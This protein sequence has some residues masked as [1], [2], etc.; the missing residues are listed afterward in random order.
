MIDGARRLAVK[1]VMSGLAAVSLAATPALADKLMYETGDTNR[2]TVVDNDPPGAAAS[3]IRD[4]A[5]GS[6]VIQLS[7]VG[8][9]NAFRI[10]GTSTRNGG[11]NDTRRS[12]LSLQLRT[13]EN[14]LLYVVVQTR[15]GIRFLIYEPRDNDRGLI[16]TRHIYTGVGRSAV[17]DQ[18]IRLERDLAADLEAGE[19]GNRLLSVHGVIARG[20]IRLDDIALSSDP[21]AFAGADTTSTGT[22]TGTSSS[23]SD[24]TITST[25]ASM[26]STGTTGS[27]AI[28]ESGSTNG[29]RVIDDKPSGA[30]ASIV[31]DAALGS[32]VIQLEG[33]RLK[34]AYSLGGARAANGGWNDKE[35]AHLSLKLR[36]SEAY[37]LY[38]AVQ[39]RRGFRYLIY[40]PRNEDRGLIRSRF[41]YNGVGSAT[42][43]GKWIMIA[44]DLAA[45]LDAGEPGNTL[46]SV[47]GLVVRGNI[48]IDDVVLASDSTLAEASSPPSFSA[49]PGGTEGSGTSTGP[50]TSAG[51][52][53][54]NDADSGSGSDA[55]SDSVTRE[56]TARTP[57]ADAN[58]A[59]TVGAGALVILDGSA[60]TDSDGHVVEAFGVSRNAT[61][62]ARTAVGSK[63]HLSGL[64]PARTHWIGKRGRSLVAELRSLLPSLRPGDAV[65]VRNGSYGMEADVLRWPVKA[66]GTASA[67]IFLM[68]ETLGGVKFSGGLEWRLAGKHLHVSGF[69]FTGTTAPVLLQGDYTRFTSNAFEQAR[70]GLG[71]YASHVEIDNNV[72]S[73]TRGQSLWHAQPQIGCGRNCVYFKHNR[74]HHNTWKDIPRT[75]SNG[76]E[77]IML[78]YGY[79]PVPQGYDNATHTRIDHNLFSNVRGDAEVISIKSNANT[80]EHNCIIDSGDGA[81]VVRMGDD[82]R[83]RNNEILAASTTAIR[84]SG[85]SNRIEHNVFET[86]NTAA[87]GIALH[88]SEKVKSSDRYYRYHAA[89]DN[90][91]ARNRFIG[92]HFS[93]R[94]YPATGILV[95]ASSN[96][97]VQQNHFDAAIG[98]EPGIRADRHRS[99]AE[100]LRD[101]SISGNGA[102]SSLPAHVSACRP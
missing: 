48:R 46:L 13:A 65:V 34:N 27:T 79:A 84:I 87:A 52:N 75:K 89:K 40:E 54:G 58:S 74:I 14:F 70:I 4:A 30:R 16:G 100:F 93:T 96:N 41:L 36:T 67:P 26:G 2:W 80:V 98:I 68:A 37:T 66:S 5:L 39:T 97:V 8:R 1:L 50:D 9:S 76:L 18:W 71:I 92:Y 57:L 23:A 78:G 62:G 101:N 17:S 86:A 63:R 90:T 7:G 94:D 83:L 24:A 12:H 19:S 42:V 61:I 88:S 91:V 31:A 35:R 51:A 47:Q 10:G 55:A 99:E 56:D 45:D 85:Q 11:W 59:S 28:Y 64:R 95:E 3:I 69:R 72:W 6:D 22:G 44:R 43:S 81:L 82:N 33:A 49:T 32:D 38:V 102:S 20:N 53:T 60:S 77:P 73:G 25:D 29:W 21:A 15:A